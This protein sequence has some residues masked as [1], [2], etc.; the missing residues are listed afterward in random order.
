MNCPNCGTE[1]FAFSVP[2][3][4]REHLSDDSAAA[5]TCPNCLHLAQAG[6]A[7]AESLEFTRI[8]EAL[9]EQTEPATAM[10]LAVGLLSSLALNRD[11]VLALFERVERAGV[12]PLLVL[13]RLAD[14]PSLDPETDLR[15]RKAQLLQFMD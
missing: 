8:S 13:D 12:D 15:R 4:L 6:D 11:R 5:A 2:P 3:A 1:M 9:P 14:D 7:P 10:V